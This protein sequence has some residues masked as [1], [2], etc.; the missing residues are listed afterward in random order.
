MTKMVEQQL[1]LEHENGKKSKQKLF[2]NA[3]LAVSLAICKA[4]AAYQEVELFTHISSLASNDMRMLPVSAYNVMKA[5]SHPTN[6]L[7]MQL[8]EYILVPMGGF[9]DDGG[10]AHECAIICSIEDGVFIFFF[11][12]DM[13]ESLELLKTAIGEAGFT[14]RVLIGLDVAS[15]ASASDKVNVSKI[16]EENS[17]NEGYH[18]K[19]MNEIGSLTECI[20]AANFTKRAGW[21]CILATYGC[22]SGEITET[23]FADLSV[24]LSVVG[25]RSRMELPQDIKFHYKI[26]WFAFLEHTLKYEAMYGGIR[27]IAMRVR[28]LRMGRQIH[29]LVTLSL[30]PD[31]A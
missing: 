12:T 25:F 2:R 26:G 7:A 20:A 19:K 14:G 4:A 27:Y 18:L 6:K 8:Q 11:Y 1:A 10:S 3:V 13:K 23:S 24:G 17:K 28:D 22:G 31:Q 29:G 21:S 16:K 9:L 15:S 30:S 5:H